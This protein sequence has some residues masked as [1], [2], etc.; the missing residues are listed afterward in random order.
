MMEGKCPA[1]ENTLRYVS[2]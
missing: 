1:P 2:P